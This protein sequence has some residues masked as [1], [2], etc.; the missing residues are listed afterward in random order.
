MPRCRNLPP[1]N[2]TDSNIVVAVDCLKPL[3]Y[4]SAAW[5]SSN[6]ELMRADKKG[7]LGV[8]KCDFQHRIEH[9]LDVAL[10]LLSWCWHCC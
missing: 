4:F 2:E 1:V 9:H 3:L 10:L 6:F 7:Y 5:N 8:G